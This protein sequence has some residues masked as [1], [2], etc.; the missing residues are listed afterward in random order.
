MGTEFGLPCIAQMPI[1]KVLPWIPAEHSG[2]GP[3]IQGQGV[4]EADEW[5]VQV[6]GVAVESVNV[7]LDGC[8]RVPTMMH[9]VSNA[10]NDM[11]VGC[12]ILETAVDQLAG[13]C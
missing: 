7:G 4:D 3:F 6:A 10:S 2:A 13:Q 8:L 11:L 1:D 12:D 9:V 5:D